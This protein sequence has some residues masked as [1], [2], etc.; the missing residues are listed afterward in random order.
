MPST[1]DIRRRIKSVKST[2]QIT[3][4]MQLVAAS[5][6]K[7]AQDQA[8]AGRHYS[9]LINKV[10]VNLKE[11]VG[12]ESH[13]LLEER[14]GD[15]EI[16]LLVTT[17]KGLCGG[18]NTNLIRK[19]LDS[20]G[21]NTTFVTVGRKGCQSIGRLKKDLLA[22]FP[23]AD[24]ASFVQ[25][26]TVSKFVLDKFL[27]D[28][29]IGRVRVAFTNFI[30]TLTQ[31]PTIE[32]LL[33]INPMTLGRVMD[34]EGVGG[35]DKPESA[36]EDFTGYEFEPNASAVFDSVLPQYVN[37]QFYQMVL[38]SRASEHS[39]R[40][41]AMKSATDNAKQLIKDLT[42]EYNKLRQASITNELLEIT[43]AMKALE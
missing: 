29:E 4:A 31:T 38:E 37:N 40:M 34:F 28:P 39:A 30:T 20:A 7:K 32:T 25:C 8:I 6:M 35:G 18:L 17:D 26:K 10:L 36:Q 5:K 22:D 27:E 41:V 23:V 14:T 12:D 3:K 1:R 33:P 19:A 13:N 16:L 2:A 15:K 43:T 11:K 42:L 9:N 21:A 24:P